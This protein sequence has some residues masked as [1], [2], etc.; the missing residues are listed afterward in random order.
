MRRGFKT[1]ARKLALEIRSEVGLDTY[2]KF[3]PY[4][5]AGEYG[6]PIY[7]LSDLGRDLAARAA[8]AHYAQDG[9]LGSADVIR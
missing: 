4:A 7:R 5:L 1:E 2:G 9:S 3:D 8:A 6:I